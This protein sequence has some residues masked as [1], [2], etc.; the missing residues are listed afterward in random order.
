MEWFN[1]VEQVLR[2]YAQ[3]H[4]RSRRKE[5]WYFMLFYYCVVFAF[6]LLSVVAFGWI[7]LQIF[8]LA[9]LIPN[10]A[11]TVR[12][13]HDVGRSGAWILIGMVPLLGWVILVIW[14]C[15]ESEPGENRYGPNPIQEQVYSNVQPAVSQRGALAVRCLSGTLRGQSYRIGSK[16]I[17]L[18][19]AASCGIRFGDGVPGVSSQHCCIRLE[20]GAPVLIDLNSRYGTW[21]ENGK[22]L[23]PNYPERLSVGSRFYLGSPGNMC[24][25]VYM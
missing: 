25:I 6:S 19:R 10:L 5:Y 16:G 17:V 20:G 23:P 24:Q 4:G 12:R 14:L 18:G 15:Q 8:L 13:L 22:R 11:V 9:M 7:L 21:L 1:S 3:F 2:K